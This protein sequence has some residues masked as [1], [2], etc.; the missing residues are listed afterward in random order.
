MK[1]VGIGKLEELSKKHPDAR[2]W[3]SNW[4]Y[5]TKESD[6]KKS[7]DIKGKYSSASFLHDNIVVFNKGN[8]YR[9]VIQVDYI[10]GIAI[11]LLADTHDKYDQWNKKRRKR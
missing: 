2:Q 3:V 4:L 6:W 7:T 9:V 8:S 5:D 1:I 10:S 11:I